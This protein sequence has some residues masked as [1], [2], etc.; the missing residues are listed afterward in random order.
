M[1]TPQQLRRNAI[2]HILDG[3]FFMIA[4]AVF[5]REIVIP[6]L[7]GELTSKKFLLGLRPTIMW[8]CVLLPQLWYVRHIEGL[9]YKK[10]TI[11][12]WAV[13]QRLGWIIFMI[14]ISV[15]WSA[16]GVTLGV[17]YATLALG[18]FGAGMVVPVWSD[19]YAK[20]TPEK[21]W[22]WVLGIRWAIPALFVVAISPITRR[23]MDPDVIGSPQNYQILLGVALFFWTASFVCATL[24]HEEHAEEESTGRRSSWLHYIKRMRWISFRRPDFRTFM[25]ANVLSHIPLMLLISYMTD[26]A[27]TLEGTVKSDTTGFSIYYFGFLALGAIVGGRISDRFGPTVPCRIHPLL[28]AAACA[29]AYFWR[30][31][32]AMVWVY[33][34]WGVAFGMW[35]VSNMPIL[36]RYAGPSRR[37][38][39]MAVSMT[40]LG[41]SG[42]SVPPLFGRLLD[43]GLLSYSHIFLISAVSAASSWALFMFGVPRWP[44]AEEHVVNSKLPPPTPD[45]AN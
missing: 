34:L 40:M 6:T 22:G 7:I 24:I 27:L 44:L 9:P 1:L 12:R 19:W 17:F 23:V 2:L 25:I 3:V 21:S 11:L 32:D 33:S 13:V 39:Y 18:A 10:P 26:Y 16:D 30:S 15:A 38:I 5:S 14:W 4:M 35:A 29:T 8:V 36:F 37:P 45:P 20:T 41:V 42:A 43:I 28:T 31:P